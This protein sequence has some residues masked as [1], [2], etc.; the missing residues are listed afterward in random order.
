VLKCP[1]RLDGSCG[2]GFWLRRSFSCAGSALLY[3]LELFDR[4]P[5]HTLDVFAYSRAELPH[6]LWEVVIATGESLD[7]Q[8]ADSIF[9][10]GHAVRLL[11][12]KPI[13]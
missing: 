10:G 8:F 4:H 13:R 1:H 6:N 2:A 11:Y 7:A 3:S 9:K 5:S 12:P